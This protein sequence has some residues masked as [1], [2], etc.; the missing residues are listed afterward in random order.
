MWPVSSTCSRLYLFFA[1]Y[2]RL[3]FSLLSAI[4]KY[5]ALAQKWKKLCIC[6]F[7]RTVISGPW[8]LLSCQSKKLKN[9]KMLLLVGKAVMGLLLPFK[10][11][12]GKL[13][14][15]L[16]LVRTAV[17]VGAFSS[18][19][20]RGSINPIPHLK[21][22]LAHKGEIYTLSKV[23]SNSSVYVLKSKKDLRMRP[24]LLVLSIVHLANFPTLAKEQRIATG[25]WAQFFSTKGILE[26][27][28]TLWLMSILDNSSPH[29]YRHSVP[30]PE[31]LCRKKWRLGCGWVC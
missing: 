7:G 2:R 24:T 11:E 28:R 3:K 22:N 5:N 17:V 13:L 12:L 10:L 14:W 9:E 19:S 6:G 26:T 16:R 25:P 18:S 1:L 29:G 8:S 21:T 4:N 15:Q 27:L 30:M 20:T 23:F 31:V